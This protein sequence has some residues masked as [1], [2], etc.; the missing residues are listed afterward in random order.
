MAGSRGV[1]VNRRVEEE[2]LSA[3]GGDTVS[4]TTVTT[5]EFQ[6]LHHT[7]GTPGAAED[8][9]LEGREAGSVFLFT[10]VDKTRV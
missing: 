2:S 7:E 10:F 8:Q 4:L 1:C 5:G 9:S 6:F 3:S